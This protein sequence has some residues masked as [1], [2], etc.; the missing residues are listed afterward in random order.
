[1]CVYEAKHLVSTMG[2]KDDAPFSVQ[3]IAVLAI[4]FWSW[5]EESR[6]TDTERVTPFTVCDDPRIVAM[7]MIPE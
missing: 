3:N 4:C 6:V 2:P 1:M 5:C 7:T